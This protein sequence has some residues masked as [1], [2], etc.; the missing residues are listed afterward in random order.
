MVA[1]ALSGL[2]T[3]IW[4]WRGRRA[5]KP[6]VALIGGTPGRLR[7]YASS[8]KRDISPEDEAERLKRLCGEQGFTAA[9]WRIG[10]EFG[11]DVRPLAWPDRGDDQDGPQGAGRG[12]DLLVDANSG[13]SVD[14]AI[15]VGA[16]LADHGIAITRSPSSGGSMT[17]SGGSARRHGGR[18]RRANRNAMSRPSAG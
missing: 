4:D 10:A 6:V 5:G 2:D 9:K 12:I 3:A 16:M 17:A 11:H 1:R 7:A 14:R 8:M 15:A 18:C 13:F